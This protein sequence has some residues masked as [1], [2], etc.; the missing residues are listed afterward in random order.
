MQPRPGRDA[1]RVPLLHWMPQ[2]CPPAAPSGRALRPVVGGTVCRPVRA[3]MSPGDAMRVDPAG[4]AR[5][6][7]PAR[8]LDYRRAVADVAQATVDGAGPDDVF[9]RIV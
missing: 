2:A 6:R 7:A 9:D 5:L 3:M 8:G 4:P 1:S